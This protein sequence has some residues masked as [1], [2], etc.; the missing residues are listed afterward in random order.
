MSAITLQTP[1]AAQPAA[2]HHA[3][4][5]AEGITGWFTDRARVEGGVQYLIFP[6]YP[7]PAWQF[8][9]TDDRPERVAMTV[10][11]GPPNWIDTEIVYAVQATAQGCE[12]HFA[13]TGLNGDDQDRAMIE[14]TWAELMQILKDY[15]ETGQA[16]PK[17]VAET[18]LTEVARV[19]ADLLRTLPA[20]AMAAP[21]PCPGFTVTELLAHIAPLLVNS[22]RA[23]RKLPLSEE[24]VADA[25]PATVADLAVQT[26]AAWAEP[27]ALEGMTTFGPGEMPATLASAITLQELAL[28]GWDL[29]RGA[30]REVVLTEDTAQAV[31]AVVEQIADQARATGGYGEALDTPAHGGP[32]ERALA[33]SGRDPRWTA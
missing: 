11:A 23:A 14:R 8:K 9:I 29:A 15:A 3:V 19:V 1:I 24:P 20:D 5:T 7:G 21:T 22:A 28:H 16:A 2:V 25:A 30:G 12:L 17:F 27:G 4:A 31:L 6:G 13:H 26:V 18:P 10:L 33:A 32:F